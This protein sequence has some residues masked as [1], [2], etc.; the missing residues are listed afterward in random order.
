VRFSKRLRN[1]TSA[2]ADVS[3]QEGHWSAIRS[4]PQSRQRVIALSIKRD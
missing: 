3:P 4:E 1:M 2:A